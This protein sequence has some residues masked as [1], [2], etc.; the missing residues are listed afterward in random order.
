MPP[1]IH[2]LI[3]EADESVR[4]C[5]LLIA[6]HFCVL[7]RYAGLKPRAI[8]STIPRTD[9]LILESLNSI[10]MRLRNKGESCR[11][12]A[13]GALAAKERRGQTIKTTKSGTLYATGE[14]ALISA[15]WV[16]RCTDFSAVASLGQVGQGTGHSQGQS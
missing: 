14:L 1:A 7:L 8:N 5:G 11:W 9:A 15:L 13:K 10:L 4:R 6:P 2:S 12:R 3:S 16:T